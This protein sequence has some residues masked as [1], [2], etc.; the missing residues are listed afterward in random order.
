[1]RGVILG[2]LV[3]FVVMM[4]SQVVWRKGVPRAKALVFLRLVMHG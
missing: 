2:E 4:E 3:F 1:L